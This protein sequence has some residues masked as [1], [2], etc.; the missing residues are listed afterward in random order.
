MRISIGLTALG[1]VA[2]SALAAGAAEEPLWAY[3]FDG[4]PSSQSLPPPTPGPPADNTIILHVEGSKLAFTRAQV[5]DF[6]GPA[7]W[8]PEDHPPMPD[9]VAHGRK[10]A[11][12]PVMACGLCH[13]PDGNGRP[14]NANLTGP[15]YDYIIQQMQDFRSGSRQTSDKRKTNTA[16]MIGFGKNMTDDEVKAAATYFASIPA[17]QS[18]KVVESDTAP[19]SRPSGKACSFPSRGMGQ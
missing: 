19:K 12:P 11:S 10:T 9:I 16:L 13:L 4:P 5:A 1:I 14:E 18:S 6:Y 17:K 15:T 7:D 3:G 2:A 8:F